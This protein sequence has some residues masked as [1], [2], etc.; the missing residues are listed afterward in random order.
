MP[1]FVSRLGFSMFPFLSFFFCSLVDSIGLRKLTL[2]SPHAFLTLS[3]SHVFYP[4]AWYC[5]PRRGTDLDIPAGGRTL[6]AVL[7]SKHGR[8]T[9]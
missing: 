9:E 2:S 3:D 6:Y 7:Y 5:Y 4:G 1:S 8:E